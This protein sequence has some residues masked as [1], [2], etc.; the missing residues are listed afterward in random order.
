MDAKFYSR[1]PSK[2][3]RDTIQP[4]VHGKLFPDIRYQRVVEDIIGQYGGS[5]SHRE[6]PRVRL[7]I[8]RLSGNDIDAVK[9]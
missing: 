9:E 8:L 1:I 3:D 2:F 4:E 7:D 6:I 5:E